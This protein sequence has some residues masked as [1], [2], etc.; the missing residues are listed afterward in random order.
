M[1]KISMIIKELLG[2]CSQI[3]MQKLNQLL[4]IRFLE[5][6]NDLMSMKS[7][8]ELIEN[9]IINHMYK[10]LKSLLG[11]NN[12]LMDITNDNKLCIHNVLTFFFEG[13]N[14]FLCFQIL[15]AFSAI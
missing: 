15:G 7:L 10:K 11:N 8:N 13:V 3:Q 14:C 6:N 2:M 12:Y 5:L 1:L 9:E 4:S